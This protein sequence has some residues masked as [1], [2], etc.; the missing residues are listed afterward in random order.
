VRA[1]RIES[2]RTEYQLNVAAGHGS[3]PYW[4]LEVQ[5]PPPLVKRLLAQRNP[6]EH[7]RLV[8]AVHMVLSTDS[9]ITELRWHLDRAFGQGD[10]STAAEKPDGVPDG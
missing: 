1:L 5:D 2:I 4:M 8:Q 10:L 9:S 6:L 3:P 7:T